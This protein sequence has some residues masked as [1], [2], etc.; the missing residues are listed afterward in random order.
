MITAAFCMRIWPLKGAARLLSS[1][2]LS[3]LSPLRDVA[4]T[5][6]PRF[7]F[8]AEQRETALRDIA[9]RVRRACLCLEGHKKSSQIQKCRLVRSACKTSNCS[10]RKKRVFASSGRKYRP[11]PP[12]HLLARP[13]HSFNLRNSSSSNASNCKK[14]D[15]PTHHHTTPNSGKNVTPTTWRSKHP[16]TPKSRDV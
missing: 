1:N 16:F 2:T 7:R 13:A 3:T 6:I 9:L 4:L 12:T 10:P 15:P 8:Q 11:A 5:S 14:I